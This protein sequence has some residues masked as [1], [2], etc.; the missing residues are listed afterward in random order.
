MGTIYNQEN[1]IFKEIINTLDS[2]E[3]EKFV[4]DGLCWADIKC[5][6][7][8]SQSDYE[9][10]ENL[11]MAQDKRVVFLLKEPNRNAGEDYRDWHWKENSTPLGRSIAFWL[12]GILKTTERYY[13]IKDELRVEREI[14]TESPFAFVNVKK[15]AGGATSDWK[16]IYEYAEKYSEQIR[17]QLDLYN[18]NIIVCCGSSDSSSNPKMLIVAMEYLY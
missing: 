17:K 3:C 5:G 15:T 1:A 2:D 9:E 14:F 11:Y 8:L 6:E 4:S 10:M 16:E 12:E 18:P 13:P 7:D